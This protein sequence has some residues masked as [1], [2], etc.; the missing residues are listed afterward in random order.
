[1]VAKK[2]SYTH[3]VDNNKNADKLNYLINVDKK[4]CRYDK[5]L[6]FNLI[7]FIQRLFETTEIPTL[8]ISAS[9]DTC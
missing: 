5:R 6:A 2:Q 1:V 8:S 3:A 4:W 7:A 9:T